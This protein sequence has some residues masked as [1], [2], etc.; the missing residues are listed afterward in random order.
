MG[1]GSSVT[2][3]ASSPTR[4]GHVIRAKGP[5]GGEP[6]V[7]HG[8]GQ[9]ALNGIRV[10]ANSCGRRRQGELARPCLMTISRVIAAR[11]PVAIPAVTPAADDR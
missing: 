5:I 9:H 3:A 1:A 2:A 4:W 10:G 6:G 11:G 7:R 8:E